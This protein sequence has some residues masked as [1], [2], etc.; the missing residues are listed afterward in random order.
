[1]VRAFVFPGQGSQRKG[2]GE[3]LFPR[4]PEIIAMADAE[5]GYSIVDLCLHDPEGRLA[6]TQY[7]Q[8]ALFVVNAL[9]YRQALATGNK[10]PDYVAGH[11]LG[12][13]NALEAAGVFDLRTG[14]TLVKK[15]GELM[16]KV[17][18]GGMAA[19]IG[20]EVDNLLELLRVAESGSIDVA[21]YNTPQQIVI[22]GP[23]DAI[24][25]VIPTIEKAGAK[26]VIPLKVSGAFH[27]RYMRA[28]QEEF[29]QFIGNFSFAAPKIP[30]IANV[31]A[32][33]YPADQVAHLLTQQIGSPVRW[34]ESI[35]YLQAHGTTE[36]EEIGPGKILTGLIRQIKR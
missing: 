27:S 31:T 19:V 11:S 12:E 14:L 35:Q 9:S 29:A 13:Y 20:L 17:K 3:E 25:R 36:F 34:L 24:Q 8:V 32:S 28:A 30:V 15:R 7:T 21:N 1:M 5:L 22:S 2:M 23:A 26:M 4:Y 6:Q 16:S 10:I 18:N 33:P